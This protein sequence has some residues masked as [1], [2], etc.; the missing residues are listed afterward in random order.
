MPGSHINCRKPQTGRC[1][2]V[3]LQNGE[4]RT[5]RQ[6]TDKMLWKQRLTVVVEDNG[7]PSLIKLQS[8]VN[9]RWRTLP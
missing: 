6:V 4:I 1:F 2:E 9:V 7:Q 8:N 3:G 5:V